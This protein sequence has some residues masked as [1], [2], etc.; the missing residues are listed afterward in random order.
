MK[1]ATCFATLVLSTLQ[2]NAAADPTQQRSL[3]T[4]TAS[5]PPVREHLMYRPTVDEARYTRGEYA[6]DD[7]RS[8]K[9]TSERYRLYANLDGKVDEMVPVAENTF[10]TRDGSTRI[11][12]DRVPLPSQVTVESLTPSPSP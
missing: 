8:L 2:L 11:V 10:V 7:G 4:T 6:L 12:F 9:V 1:L 3:D 5:R